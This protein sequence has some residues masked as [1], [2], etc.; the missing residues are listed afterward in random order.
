M[1][2]IEKERG[3]FI[4][5]K[6]KDCS[7]EQITFSK[8]AQKINCRSCGSTL[9]QSSSGKGKFVNGELVEVLQQ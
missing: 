8:P 9:I 2:K 1:E 6:C 5:V 3:N 4:K 7:N